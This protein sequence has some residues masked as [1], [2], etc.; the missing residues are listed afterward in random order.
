M[1]TYKKEDYEMNSLTDIVH[2]DELGWIKV[3]QKIIDYFMK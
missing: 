1:W 3:N 2:L